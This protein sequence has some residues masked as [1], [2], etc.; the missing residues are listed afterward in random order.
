VGNLKLKSKH[1]VLCGD[2]TKA[3]DVERLMDGQ[4][5]GVLFTDPPYG[6]DL[7][8]DYSAI[9]KLDKFDAKGRSYKKVVGD[10]VPFDAA[11]LLE[12]F[13]STA[14][15]L[16]WGGDWY[17][18]T[19]PRGGSWIV[20]NKRPHDSTL[21]II[22]NHF[23]M[24]WSKVQRR[25]EVIN[26][27]W[28]GFTARNPDCKREHPTEKPVAVLVRVL[29]G[30]GSGMDLVADPFLGSGTTLI[31]AEQLGRKCYG[32]EISPAYCDVIVNRWQKL[33]GEKAVNAKTGEPFSPC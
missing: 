27:H 13:S 22:G 6:M 16:L 32:L 31:A 20:W 15:V 12:Q 25:R 24:I 1:R 7:E 11:P 33:T 18:E 8:T 23:E 21:S 19:L 28:V 9:D 30:L 26:H 2:S 14:E 4:R 10:S 29:D 5:A 17:Y 3:D